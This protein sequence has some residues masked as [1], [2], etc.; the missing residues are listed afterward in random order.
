MWQPL[1]HLPRKHFK[2]SYFLDSSYLYVYILLPVPDVAKGPLICCFNFSDCCPPIGKVGVEMAAPDDLFSHLIVLFPNLS[3]DAIV[4]IFVPCQP[5][6]ACPE[7]P[8]AE[9]KSSLPLS[10]DWHFLSPVW[11]VWYKD[12]TLNLLLLLFEGQLWVIPEGRWPSWK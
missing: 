8:Q 6:A 12:Q 1:S 11:Y 5:K 3:L 9:Q 7:N 10:A 4:S 2:P